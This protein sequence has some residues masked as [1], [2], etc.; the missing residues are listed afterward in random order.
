MTENVGLY[1]SSLYQPEGKKYLSNIMKFVEVS[2]S[3]P[4]LLLPGDSGPDGL[5]GLVMVSP[6]PLQYDSHITLPDGSLST[7]VGIDRLTSPLPES[8][9]NLW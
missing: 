7:N 4:P 8:F 9:T 3:P 5:P 2:G 6:G 1:Q